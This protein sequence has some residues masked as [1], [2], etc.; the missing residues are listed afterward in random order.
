VGGWGLTVLY[1]EGA[2]LTMGTLLV[3][4]R[5]GNAIGAILITMG[6]MWAIIFAADATVETIASRGHEALASWI[7][8]GFMMATFPMLWLGNTLIWLVFPHSR[9]STRHSRTYI[10]VTGAGTLSVGELDLTGVA[11]RLDDEGGTSTIE[12]QPAQGRYVVG[13]LPIAHLEG[14]TT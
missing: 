2:L 13:W 4:R 6:T 10:R 8:L 1:G 7:A 5:P 12:D 9:T 14:A 3:L 11:D